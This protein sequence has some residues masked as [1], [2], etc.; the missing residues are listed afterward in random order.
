MASVGSCHVSVPDLPS[1]HLVFR[2]LLFV[3]FILTR[4]WNGDV[5]RYSVSYISC[6]LITCLSG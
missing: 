1:H 4:K 6:D 2:S 3:I 5:N